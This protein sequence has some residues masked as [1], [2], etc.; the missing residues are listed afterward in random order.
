MNGRKR[1]RRDGPVQAVDSSSDRENQRSTGAAQVKTYP[2]RPE[3]FN[4][5]RSGV[6]TGRRETSGVAAR[7]QMRGQEVLWMPS[8][9]NSRSILIPITS[10][11]TPSSPSSSPVTFYYGLIRCGDATHSFLIFSRLPNVRRTALD[12]NQHRCCSSTAHLCHFTP[13]IGHICSPLHQTRGA[14][15]NRAQLDTFEVLGCYGG[16][17]AIAGIAGLRGSSTAVLQ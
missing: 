1:P 4:T 11:H 13:L 3:A 16:K 2:D 7:G 8:S 9:L 12:E 14:L 6:T 17:S 5:R 10:Q 15:T